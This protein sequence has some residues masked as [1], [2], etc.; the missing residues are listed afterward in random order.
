MA[1]QPG[2]QRAAVR[3]GWTPTDQIEVDPPEAESDHQ[4]D[5]SG[6]DRLDVALR[7]GQAI[8]HTEHHLAEHD[9]REQPEALDQ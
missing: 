4:G 9:D 7:V 8:D 5:Q 3:A 2:R 6:A 1:Q